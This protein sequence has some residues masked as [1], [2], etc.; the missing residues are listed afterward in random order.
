[1]SFL[2]LNLNK[3]DQ[4]T[5]PKARKSRFS[6]E[7][8]FRRVGKSILPSKRGFR[9]F[10]NLILSSFHLSDMSESPFY[11]HFIV[12]D[13]SDTSFD[14]HFTHPTCRKPHFMLISSIRRFGNHHLSTAPRFHLLGAISRGFRLSAPPPAMFPPRLRRS[15]FHGRFGSFHNHIGT[16]SVSLPGFTQ[17]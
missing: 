11:I 5:F 1:M 2:I 9:R 12:S 17:Q 4:K 8:P 13:V 14:A 3:T 16:F 6:S 10:G 7:P 15:I